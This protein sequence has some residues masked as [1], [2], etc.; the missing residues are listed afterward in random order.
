MAA[1]KSIATLGDTRARPFLKWAGGKGQLLAQFAALYP[2]QVHRY[3]EPFVGSG[4]VFFDLQAKFPGLR[5]VLSDNNKELI[6]CY[7]AVQD[8]VEGL[9]RRLRQ[10]K[11]RH[12]KDHYYK[13]RGQPTDRLTAPRRA[14]RL[15]YLNK[16]CYNGLYRVN[17]R[18]DFNVP[19]GSYSSPSVFRAEALRRASRA[20]QRVRLGV[21]DFGK[22]IRDARPGTFVYIDP[23]YHP[24][25]K[26]A[27]FTGYTEG[28]FGLAEQE[29]LSSLF[30]ELDGKGCL[31][32]LSNSDTRAIRKLYG[33][34]RIETVS[35][36]RAINSNGKRRGAISELVVMNYEPGKG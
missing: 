2:R 1:P 15:I 29:R 18:G 34:Y 25:S 10:H 6:D 20:L 28:G 33:G 23:P 22:C 21:R 31:V 3:I 4:A 35:A 30:A 7:R 11:A 13:V 17:S 14:A 9:I 19:I 16:T 26:T 32:M 12:G 27:N 8:D 24:V 5:A 36:R